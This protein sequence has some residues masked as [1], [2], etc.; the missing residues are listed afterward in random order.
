M[1]YHLAAMMKLLLVLLAFQAIE[2]HMT[3]PDT[4]ALSVPPPP[5]EEDTLSL[6]QEDV[7]ETAVTKYRVT[8][9]TKMDECAKADKRKCSNVR[10]TNFKYASNGSF[11]LSI[12]QGRRNSQTAC[13]KNNREW[14]RVL[15][16]ILRRT[17]ESSQKSRSQHPRKLANHGLL[18]TSRSTQ[19]TNTQGLALGCTTCLSTEP[20]STRIALKHSLSQKV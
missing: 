18:R 20:S 6:I 7:Q 10:S 4:Y 15:S 12:T 14:C 16:L 2:G 9:Q 8:W 11:K 13:G 1:G 17:L 3:E 5:G 19:T